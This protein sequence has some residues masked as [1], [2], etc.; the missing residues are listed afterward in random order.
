VAPLRDACSSYLFL[1]CLDCVSGLP[2]MSLPTWTAHPL[3]GVC[4]YLDLVWEVT[5]LL[6]EKVAPSL[7]D[8]CCSCVRNIL[9][10]N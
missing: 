4:S 1:D 5:G 9:L 2:R 3:M 6:L 7:R 10:F 8:A